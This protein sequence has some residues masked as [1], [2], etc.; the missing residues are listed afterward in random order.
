MLH[1][2]T[3]INRQLKP[4]LPCLS[5]PADA[6]SFTIRLVNLQTNADFLSSYKSACVLPRHLG[7]IVSADRILTPA[8]G[9]GRPLMVFNP[10][11]AT[12]GEQ[13]DN[14]KINR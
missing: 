4:T 11:Q 10:L 13:I 7:E 1:K 12:K 3:I 6:P 14:K 5:D 2:G 8:K 9:Q